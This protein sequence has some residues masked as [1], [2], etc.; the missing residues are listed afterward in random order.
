M[1]AEPLAAGQP[2]GVLAPMT[3][4]L[5]RVLRVRRETPGVATLS[6]APIEGAPDPGTPG[7]FN[8]LWAFGVGEAAISVSGVALDGAVLH[9]VRDVGPVSRAL[10]RTRPGTVLGV[11]GPY[12][13]GWDLQ[14]AVGGDLVVVAGGLGFAPLRPLIRALSVQRQSFGR[15][16]VLVGARSPE[17]LLYLDETRRWLARGLNIDV[18]VDH[19]SPGWNG[20]VGLVTR[21]ID[22]AIVH[23][24]ATTAFVCGPEVMMRF[25][26][27]ALVAAGVAPSRV[28]LSMERNMRCGIGLCG[29]CQLG[30]LFICRDGPVFTYD[31][32]GPLMEVR[33]L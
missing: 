1:A 18:T 21:L 15:I 32:I 8:M 26:A 19:A 10:C 13:R 6:V 31:A 14:G 11:R 20:Q 28:Q 22:A 17:Q 9:T 30:P 23:P 5:H 4:R 7:Q 29:H 24:D 3:P 27:R 12:G 16:N 2:A 25:T 33:E